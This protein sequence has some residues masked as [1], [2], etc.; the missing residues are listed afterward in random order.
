MEFDIYAVIGI[1]C[2]ILL[3]ICGIAIDHFLKDW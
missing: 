1:A 2:G 3:G